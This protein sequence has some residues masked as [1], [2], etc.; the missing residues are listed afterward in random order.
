V[1]ASAASEKID[2][3]TVTT[4]CGG[5]KTLIRQAIEKTRRWRRSNQ[6]PCAP[7]CASS[8]A[9][10]AS[11]RSA[12]VASSADCVAR[13]SAPARSASSVVKRGMSSVTRSRLQV[14]PWLL[15]GHPATP[16]IRR[17]GTG[18]LRALHA[19]ALRTSSSAPIPRPHGSVQSPMAAERLGSAS[20]RTTP[21]ICTKTR[22]STGPTATLSRE[23][24]EPSATSVSARS[25]APTAAR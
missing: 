1:A 21:T 17:R 22:R 3:S 9:G 18:T 5:V 12:S 20:A 2:R 16:S 24:A 25:L 13:R 14:L 8:W 19:P 7:S 10:T 23:R 11:L 15:L 6:V 4:V